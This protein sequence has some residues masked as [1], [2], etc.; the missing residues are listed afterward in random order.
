M[1]IAYPLK[2]AVFSVQIETFVG[3]IFN[4]ADTETGRVGIYQLIVCIH[5]G[6]GFVE[7]GAFR[8]PELRRID[9]EVLFKRLP[10]IDASFVFFTCHYLSIR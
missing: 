7:S 5:F 8:R 4:A 10:V 3:N 1:V 2:F 6:Y 9:D